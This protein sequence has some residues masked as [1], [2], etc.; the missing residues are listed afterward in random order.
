KMPI[1]DADSLQEVYIR[2]KDILAL[3]ARCKQRAKLVKDAARKKNSICDQIELGFPYLTGCFSSKFTTP[4]ILFCERY[5]N[6]FK[7]KRLGKEKLID[8]LIKLG[9]RKDVSNLAESIYQRAENACTLFGGEDTVIDYKDLQ[10]R[11]RSEF[12][13]F[14]ALQKEIDKVD[15][16]IKNLYQLCFPKKRLNSIPG[17]ADIIG[18]NIA[19]FIGDAERFSSGRSAVGYFGFYPKE[20]SSGLSSKK[21]LKITKAGPNIA[22][23]DLYLAAD[24]ARLIDP[25]LGKIYY[26]QMIV[27]GNP[28]TKAICRVVRALIPRILRVMKE[29]RDY[30]ICDL[31]GNPISKEEGRKIVKERFF[32]PQEVRQRLSNRKRVSINKKGRTKPKY[33]RGSKAP[34]LRVDSSRRIA[35]SLS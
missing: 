10:D 21:G 20:D 6:P 16:K 8:T 34:Q 35:P 23:K 9:F 33:V 27:K 12:R 24:T 19:S 4:F 5:A 17:I 22:K 3:N 32:V 14:R 31:K 13:I 28:H 26:E 25:E 1:V 15:Q 7:V 11:I 29:D 2:P 18:S 30:V